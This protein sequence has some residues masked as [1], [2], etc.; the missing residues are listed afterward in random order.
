MT[1][2]QSATNLHVVVYAHENCAC[3]AAALRAL[4][5]AGA[6]PCVES[7]ADQPALRAHYD[8][9]SPIVLIDGRVRFI[10]E[11]EPVL[12]RRLLDRLS[13]AISSEPRD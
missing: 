3:L 11:V 9:A 8:D 2:R 1:N 12:L 5:D 10:G 13:P 6:R 4:R 7:L